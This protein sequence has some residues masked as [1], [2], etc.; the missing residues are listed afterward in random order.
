MSYLILFAGIYV[1][2]LVL[3]LNFWVTLLIAL[4]LFI[5]LPVHRK[6]YKKQ[7]NEQSRFE[8]I[9]IYIDS[10]LYAF[11]KERKVV[12]A[13]EDVC[14]CL[15][16][17]RLKET[18]RLALEHMILTFDDT[19]ILLNSLNMVE[20]EYK[21]ERIASIHRFMCDVEYY[22]GDIEDSVNILIEDKNRWVKR[23]DVAIA[24]RKR[25]F[26]EIVLSVIASILICGVIL[27]LPI[28]EIDISKNILVQLV[29]VVVVVIDEII[30][31]LGQKKLAMDWLRFDE[32][33]DE[34]LC[35]KRLEEYR[36]Y[37]RNKA[38]RTSILL[39]IIPAGLS[40]AAFLL[41]KE[42][43]AVV[44]MTIALICANQHLIGRKIATEKITKSLSSVFPKWLIYMSLLLQS[45]NVYMSL[46]KS[47][48]HAPITLKNDLI[49]LISKLEM[50][51][52][53][54]KP[55]HEF[56]SEFDLPQIHSAM[57][58]LYSISI[59]SSGNSSRQIR[60]L[61]TRNLSMMD[62][63][64]MERLRNKNSGMYILF[65]APV[66][67]ASFKLLTD[68]AMFLLAFLSTKVM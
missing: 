31:L 11:V 39:S 62:L 46:R 59:G 43:Y 63:A 21:C 66:L 1:L 20:E 38:F 6:I 55:F 41:G 14:S 23:I 40:I 4:Y 18:V 50:N 7:K 56:L 37:D 52:E 32:M 61:V 54:A 48:E 22:G 9:S 8:E 60:E 25:M 57:G 53:S 35:A 5:M 47:L 19:E 17:G 36:K 42:W 68:M 26:T 51:P 2:Q 64:D 24:E 3:K 30:V 44:F 34:K 27:H 12:S 13:F 28:G 10:L 67:T 65:L 16:N 49:R 45:E 58:M 33:E 15:G 29:S